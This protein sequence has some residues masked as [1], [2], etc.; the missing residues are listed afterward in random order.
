MKNADELLAGG[1]KTAKVIDILGNIS[2]KRRAKT[3]DI[4]RAVNELVDGAK[5]RLHDIRNMGRAGDAA[6]N[7]D[8]LL[9]V[10]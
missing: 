9:G 4:A 2:R 3:E 6:K 8:D 7:L 1:K 5:K 10:V